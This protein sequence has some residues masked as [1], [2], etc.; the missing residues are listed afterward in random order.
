M[1]A[2]VTIPSSFLS[3]IDNSLMLYDETYG[4]YFAEATKGGRNIE[5]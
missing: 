1:G 2:I 5:A 3:D 4:P